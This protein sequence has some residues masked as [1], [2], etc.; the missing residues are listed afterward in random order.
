MFGVDLILFDVDEVFEKLNQMDLIPII[1]VGDNIIWKPWEIE[2][3]TV[4]RNIV[5]VVDK[6]MDV[7]VHD[8][9]DYVVVR[10]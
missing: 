5:Q 6:W 3:K 1:N 4:N 2:R 9:P 8:Q 7:Y 10:K